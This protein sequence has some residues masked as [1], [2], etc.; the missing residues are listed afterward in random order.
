MRKALIEAA[1][2]RTLRIQDRRTVDELSQTLARG[3]TQCNATELAQVVHECS[4]SGT[5]WC[6]E[7]TV[8][9]LSLVALPH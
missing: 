3:A 2:I 4:A 8:Q 9:R 5:L 7:E 6:N 1:V